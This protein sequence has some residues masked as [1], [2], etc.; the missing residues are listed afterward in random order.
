MYGECCV[1][2]C[3]IVQFD[4]VVYVCD[5]VF[6]QV[7]V[8]FCVCG[9][10]VGVVVGEFEEYVG[11]FGRWDVGVFVG[12]IDSDGFIGIVDLQLYWCVRR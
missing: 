5:D 8:Q 12:Y 3:W 1:G 7:E 9:I 6:D 2:F 11:M 10:V 4:F